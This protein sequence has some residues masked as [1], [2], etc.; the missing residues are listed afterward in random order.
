MAGKRIVRVRADKFYYA[1]QQARANRSKNVRPSKG[2]K[3]QVDKI[4][5]GKQETKFVLDAPW[6]FDSSLSLETFTGFTS[7]ITSTAEV[8]ALIPRVSQGQDDHN[9]VGNII[10]PVSL[11]T[12]VN[13]ALYTA[14]SQNIYADVYFCHSKTVKSANNTTGVVVS[15]LLNAGDGTNVGYDGTS[16]TAMLPV[17]KSE[18]TVIAHKR[19][20]LRKVGGNPNYELDNSLGASSI[21]DSK[22]CASFAQ[23]IK[24]P[25]RLVYEQASNQYPTN[26]FPFMM[27]GF[28]G[29]DS[30]GGIAPI[31]ARLQVQAQSHLYYKDS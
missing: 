25:Q 7:G 24:L 20:L 4:M 29:A 3:L 17:N 8:Y 13:L 23:K 5:A 26:T 12:K 19:V 6:N 9:R 10:Q 28:C 16:Y 22:Y 2:L 1:K 18:F 27:V 21:S 31:T 14:H 11:T 15:A 30:M